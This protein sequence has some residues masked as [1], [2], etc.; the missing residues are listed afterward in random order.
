MGK[1]KEIKRTKLSDSQLKS[2]IFALFNTG[3]TGKTD[4]YGLIRTK[5]TLARGR[6][7]KMYDLCLAEWSKIKEQADSEATIQAAGEAAK[8]GLKS[9]IEKQVHIQRLIDSIQTDIDNGFYETI[10][11]SVNPQILQIALSPME[12]AALGKTI[13]DL[14]AELNKMEGD[15]A[16]TKT[17]FTDTSGNDLKITLN[18]S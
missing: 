5:Y 9:K 18:I 10:A 6:Y 11:G 8:N 15:Y 1:K 3:N 16:P 4:L 17:A 12:K 2:E 13:K 7:F 14:Y